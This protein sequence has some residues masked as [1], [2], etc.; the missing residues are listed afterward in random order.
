MFLTLL[1]LY[2]CNSVT[3]QPL[4]TGTVIAPEVIQESATINVQPEITVMPLLSRDNAISHIALLLPMQS[5]S[6][7]TAAAAV[8]MG[9]KAAAS[10]DP[11]ALPVQT[12][13]KF[14]ESSDVVA[15]YQEAVANGAQA[16]VGPLTRNGV[17]TLAQMQ[18]FPVPTLSLNIPVLPAHGNLYYFGMA[19]EAEA[20]QVAVLARSQER[21]QAIVISSNDVLSQRLQYAFED[22][23][24]ALGGSLL[25]EIIFSG[26]TSVFA[27]LA[28]APDNMVFFATNAEKSRTIRPFLPANLTAYGTSQLFV[29]N[30]NTLL[31]FDLEGVQFV[32]M[33]WLLQPDQ[34]VVTA[35]PHASP[36]LSIDLERMYAL[37][38]DAYRLVKILIDQQLQTALPLDGVTGRISLS[39]HTFNREA[40]PA[41]FVQ[42]H[43]QAADAVKTQAE[44]MFPVQHD[45]T[46]PG[47]ADAA[48]SAPL[49]VKP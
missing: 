36:P 24:K 30:T 5:T 28:A 6:F 25:R 48:I 11:H 32:D 41:F 46:S 33:P 27:E 2:A 47:A 15:A 3:A 45:S 39:E 4:A 34:A 22:Q 37:G 43:V 42:G 20:R 19:I 49:Q 23:W 7:G 13:G 38:V 16:V 40:V 1:A 44:P 17:T 10:L 29:S 12:Y 31:N 9:F 21:Q 18:D 26:D 35:Y 8:Q 14:D